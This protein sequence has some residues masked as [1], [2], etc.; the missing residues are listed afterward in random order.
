[1]QARWEAGSIRPALCLEYR[2]S[3]QNVI[4]DCEC[5]DETASFGLPNPFASMHRQAIIYWQARIKNVLMRADTG[6][7]NRN[8]LQIGTSQ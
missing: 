5:F 1:M 4:G 8:K 6:K 3:F 7:T 2:R